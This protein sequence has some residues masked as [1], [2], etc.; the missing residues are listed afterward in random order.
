MRIIRW[1]KWGGGGGNFSSI[2]GAESCFWKRNRSGRV[3]SKAML[4]M[5]VLLSMT[6]VCDRN[7][8]SRCF[9]WCYTWNER[10]EVV[11][12]WGLTKHLIRSMLRIHQ[13]KAATKISWRNT[14]KFSWTWHTCLYWR[15]EGK[16]QCKSVTPANS[17]IGNRTR[18]CLNS[19]CDDLVNILEAAELAF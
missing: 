5:K 3:E 7:R 15:Q 16:G 17:F 8:N 19:T 1:E 6:C 11:S 18:G 4:K 14:I 12:L 9:R 10:Q 13:Q 2:P